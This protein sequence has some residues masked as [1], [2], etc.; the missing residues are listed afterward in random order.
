[1][2]QA[3]KA[4]LHGAPRRALVAPPTMPPNVRDTGPCETLEVILGEPVK[5]TG[6]LPKHTAKMAPGITGAT[7]VA[8]GT[9]SEPLRL[10]GHTCAAHRRSSR[11]GTVLRSIKASQSERRTNTLPDSLTKARFRRVSRQDLSVE[12][13]SRSSAAASGIVSRSLSLTACLAHVPTAPKAWMLPPVRL[14]SPS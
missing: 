4:I 7:S 3:A 13:R 6:Y 8:F 9:G 5:I 10:C 12:G 14:H 2:L 1:M 11:A